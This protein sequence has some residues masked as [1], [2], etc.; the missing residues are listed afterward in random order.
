[1]QRRSIHKLP[2]L[3]WL[4]QPAALNSCFSEEAFK[5]HLKK[6]HMVHLQATNKLVEGTDM[7]TLSLEELIVKASKNKSKTALLNHAA[8]AWNHN[9]FWQCMSPTP[10]APSPTLIN[11]F[12][13]HFG[14]LEQFKEKFEQFA[15]VH[16][17]SGWTW[18]VD[19][20]GHME[21]I[22]TSN[23][24]T[25]ITDPQYT[26][27]LVLDLWE[28]AYFLDYRESRK[29]YLA[30]W[31]KVVNW[32]FVAGQLKE[33]ESKNT[34]MQSSTSAQALKPYPAS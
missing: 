27:L 10:S 30:Q 22:N 15:T 23:S 21:V 26:P 25:V 1:M 24:G 4:D 34:W 17:G 3:N 14:G 28:H 2:E 31:W 13:L 33:A 32:K 11:S 5:Q 6:H 7:E 8:E 16:L 29:E 20:D 18:L 19:R 9:F 12:E